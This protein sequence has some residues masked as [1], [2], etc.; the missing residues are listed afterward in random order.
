MFGERLGN[1]D[2]SWLIS[3]D[4]H[5]ARQRSGHVAAANKRDFSVIHVC[6]PSSAT[7]HRSAYSHHGRTLKIAARKSPLIPIDSVSISIPPERSCSASSRS[8]ANGTRCS[9]KSSRSWQAHQPA[10]LEI[11]QI[12]TGGGKLA[13]LGIGTPD[14]AASSSTLTCR[15][16]FSGPSD[17][18]RC[19][20]RRCAVFRLSMVCTQS[21]FSAT[22]RVLLLC[23]CPIKCQQLQVCGSERSFRAPPGRSFRRNHVGRALPRR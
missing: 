10:Q 9:S 5:S 7:K 22:T 19:S 21:K 16:I 3:C 1:Q 6:S 14:L 23:R 12:R 18:G 20:L 15:Q 11:G 17:S 2:V 13:E 8:F 4:Q